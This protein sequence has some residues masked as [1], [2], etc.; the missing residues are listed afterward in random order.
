[1]LSSYLFPA[2]TEGLMYRWDKCLNLY[3]DHVEIQ[4]ACPAFLVL[5]DIYIEATGARSS[6]AN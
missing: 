4:R 3:S 1:M 5:S 6:L 2:G